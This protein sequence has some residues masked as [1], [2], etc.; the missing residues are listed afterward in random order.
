MEITAVRTTGLGDTTFLVA[1]DGT[2]VIV[3]PQRDVDRF[4]QAASDAGVDIS[5]VL[6]THVHNDYLSG[7][8]ELAGRTGAALVLPAA[9]GVAFGHVPAFHNEDLN[10]GPFAIRP[11]HTPGHTP[12]HMSYLV[13][14]DDQPIALFSGGSLLVGSAGR[15]DLLGIER[16]E[17]LARLQWISVN[18]LAELPD[19]V[20]LYPTHGK[21]SF[22]TSTIAGRATSTI[23]L[24]KRSN[25]VLNYANVEAFVS[26]EL[27]G[28]QPYPSYYGHMA[29]INLMGPDPLPT[30]DLPEVD[31]SSL[32]PDVSLVDIRPRSSVAAGHIPRSV[33]LEMSDR[34]G[35]WAGWLLPFDATVVL[36]AEHGQDVVEVAKQFG[37][38]GFD[39]VAGVVYDLEP[40]VA[41]NGP[42]ASF[43]TRTADDLYEALRSDSP[44]QVLDVRSPGDWEIGSLEGS[45]FRYT[46]SLLEGIPADLDP[47]RDVWIVCT[48]GFRAMAA[49]TFLEQ[50]GFRPVVVAEGG[51]ADVLHRAASGVGD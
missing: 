43:E 15:P 33:A 1:H 5:H 41:A 13:L 19:E 24:E 20:G 31:S 12:E 4:E 14:V 28:L 36:I 30:I 17:Q 48:T 3:D 32:P 34:V 44:P 38:I 16:A 6:E 8:R 2:G 46:P 51:V 22:C 9:A 39:H 50:G 49:S 40:W 42:L 45:I 35:V 10:G 47:G 23:G 18:R 21:G 7:G 27:G 11:I 25:P 29:P 26:G 37:R